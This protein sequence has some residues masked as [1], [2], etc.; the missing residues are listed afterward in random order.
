M[1]KK[2]DVQRLP[3]EALFQKEIDALIQAEQD[4]VPTGWNM[5]P[6]SVLTYICGGKAGDMDISPKYIGNRVLKAFDMMD[7]QCCI[8]IYSGFEQFL[9]ILIALPVAGAINIVM[10]KIINQNQ[11]RHTFQTHF[12]ID[13]PVCP[14]IFL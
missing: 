7:I 11:I 10:R 6:R 5:S 2:N 13:F 9:D 1:G 12:Q 3:A 4:P 14:A 8:Y